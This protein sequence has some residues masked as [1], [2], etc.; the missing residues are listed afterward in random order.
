MSEKII[1]DRRLDSWR[2][3]IT[4]YPKLIE[5]ID[6]E[7]QA[8][9]QLSLPQYDVLIELFETDKKRLRMFE[10]AQRV[11]LSRSSI[12]RLTD[13]LTLQG[14]LTRETDPADRRGSYAV[15]TEAGETA[16]KNAWPI[17]REAIL[18]Q[19]GQFL[20]EEEAQILV[21]VFS[22]LHEALD[23]AN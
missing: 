21:Q 7:L 11:V 16:L 1:S 4:L 10:L 5:R 18:R 12:T 22:R 23:A 9:G 2:L 3:F 14:M 15:L 8:A 17:Y 6:A 13:Q 19:F 20:S